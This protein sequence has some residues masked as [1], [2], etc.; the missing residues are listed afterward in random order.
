MAFESHDERDLSM[1]IRAMLAAIW[2]RKVRIVLVTVLFL[3][4]TYAILLFVPKMYESEA[5]ILVAPRD[6]VYTRA[7]GDTGPSATESTAD[8]AISSQIELI[9]SRDTLQSVIESEGLRDVKEFTDPGTSIVGMISSLLGRKPAARDIDETIL[10]NLSERLSVKRARD[11][12][13]IGVG[14]R[15]EDPSLAARLANAIANAHVQRRAAL[16]LSDT[17]E[18]SVWLE[19][20]IE[21]LRTKVA[22]AEAKV[23]AFKVD[24]DL[25]TSGSSNSSVVDQ[26][27][28]SVAS[29]IS[30]AQERMNTALSRATLIDGLLK[31]GQPVEGVADIRDS[32]TIQQLT[33]QKAQLQGEKA[34]K[35]ATLLPNHPDVQAIVAQIAEIDK[36]IGIE[37]QRAAAALKSEAKIES[38]LIASLQFELDRLKSSAGTAT[39]QTVTL[40]GLQR[41]AKAQRDL[42]ENYLIRYRDAASRTDINASLP[43]VR[44]VTLAAA[45]VSPASPKTTFILAAVGIVSVVLQVG[46]ILFSELMSGRALV[47]RRPEKLEPAQES[48]HASIEPDVVAVPQTVTE[49]QFIVSP[50]ADIAEIDEVAEMPPEPAPAEDA[51]NDDEEEAV[52][53]VVQVQEPA[54]PSLSELTKLSADIGLGRAR[55]VVLAAVGSQAEC[56]AVA[57]SLTGDALRRG[58]SVARV[59]AASGVSSDEPG[60]TDLAADLASFG[61]VVQKSVREGLSEVPW[62]QLPSINRRSMKPVTLVEAL[63][64]IYEVVLVSTGR[65][66]VASSLP[67]FAGLD[68]RLVLVTNQDID[69]ETLEAAE[70][71]AESLGYHPVQVVPVPARRAA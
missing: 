21:T 26:Q 54:R 55:V 43:D 71:D 19:Q 39:R 52:E 6:N 62:G 58:L 10:A 30:A 56:A 51:A 60:L 53:P 37:G 24:N 47:I 29:Q 13:V 41:E 42:L 8:S 25:L 9:K 32:A 59:D 12:L 38:G 49:D 16:S 1:D 14:V 2:A 5:G 18:A 63:T 22:D 57:E 7:T 17:A 23:A 35:L 34:Q 31:D 46:M 69:A 45:S 67:V 11:S 15:S 48:Q 65:V 27:I 68:C 4:A 20:Q 36:Q 33:Q 64:D 40:D 61:D 44:V 3:A 70:L 50:A 66:G 28:S